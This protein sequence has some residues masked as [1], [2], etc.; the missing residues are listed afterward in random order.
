MKEQLKI[1]H[2]IKNVN[3]PFSVDFKTFSPLTFFLE[4]GEPNTG[5][6]II[7]RHS[8][9]II[10]VTRLLFCQNNFPMGG[11]IL[12]KGQLDHSYFLNYACYDI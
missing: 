8:S 10:R 7:N 11:I 4:C 12:A 6:N 3:L 1:I 5:L 9:K 2:H